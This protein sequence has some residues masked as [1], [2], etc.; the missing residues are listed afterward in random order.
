MARKKPF[1]KMGR[2][3]MLPIPTPAPTAPAMSPA[4]GAAS[5]PSFTPSAISGSLISSA[6]ACF[7]AHFRPASTSLPRGVNV[8]TILPITPSAASMYSRRS[9]MKPT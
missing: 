8:N 3:I 4:T 6:F 1:T 7:F 2:P 5:L 9:S